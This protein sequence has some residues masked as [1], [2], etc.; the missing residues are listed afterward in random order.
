MSLNYM[1]NNPAQWKLESVARKDGGSSCSLQFGALPHGWSSVIFGTMLNLEVWIDT[2]QTTFDCIHSF[3]RYEHSF[4]LYVF[5]S[6]GRS[7]LE[8]FDN[9]LSSGMSDQVLRNGSLLIA[10]NRN[11]FYILLR[12]PS[13]YCYVSGSSRLSRN[14]MYVIQT[15]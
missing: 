7:Y 9:G 5:K 4:M 12:S 11:H 3:L 6:R 15:M 2:K 1:W 10:S 14:L 13:R 8:R